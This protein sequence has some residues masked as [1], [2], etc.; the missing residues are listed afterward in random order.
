MNNTDKKLIRK[1]CGRSQM[2]DVL[3]LNFYRQYVMPKLYKQGY[4]YDL[5]QWNSGQHK[6]CINQKT[7]EWAVTVSEAVAKD[8]EEAFGQALLPLIKEGN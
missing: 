2:E 7:E 4:Y 6:V 3:D 5:F 8:P 1:W